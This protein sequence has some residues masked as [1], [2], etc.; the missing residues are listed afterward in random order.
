MVVGSPQLSCAALGV[1]SRSSDRPPVCDQH[2]T[3]PVECG[4]YTRLRL[5]IRSGPSELEVSE[6]GSL[7][8]PRGIFGISQSTGVSTGGVGRR[9]RACH[10]SSVMRHTHNAAMANAE[11][12]ADHAA[13]LRRCG[14]PPRSSTTRPCS[15]CHGF[16]PHCGN[17]GLGCHFGLVGHTFLAVSRPS[18]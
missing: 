9:R 7:K 11:C 13:L 17:F 14:Q 4:M 2:L 16:R 15:S 6:S 18:L 3:A 8:N 5:R 12:C 1:E 10:P